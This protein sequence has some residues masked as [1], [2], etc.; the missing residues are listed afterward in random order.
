MRIT[1]CT[2]GMGTGRGNS[3]YSSTKCIKRFSCDGSKISNQNNLN[4]QKNKGLSKIGNSIS[5][6][7]DENKRIKLNW[8]SLIEVD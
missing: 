5:I 4:N 2:S 8:C 3:V 6:E 7:T 1:Y